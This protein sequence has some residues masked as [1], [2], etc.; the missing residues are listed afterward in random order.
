LSIDPSLEQARI[1]ELPAELMD[2]PPMYSLTLA[3]IR[4]KLES[5]HCGSGTLVKAGDRHFILTASHCIKPLFE[6]DQIGLPIRLGDRP[7]LIQKLPPIHVGIPACQDWGPDLAFIPLDPIDVANIHNS[8][9][10][11]FYNLDIHQEEMLSGQPK[12]DYHLWA[13]VGSPFDECDFSHPPRY[14]FMRNTFNVAIEKTITNHDFDYLEVRI[15]L[16]DYPST[17]LQGVSG[18]GLWHAEVERDKFTRA[19]RLLTAPRLEGVAFLRTVKQ[20]DGFPRIRFHG[21]RSIYQHGLSAIRSHF[22]R[23]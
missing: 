5:I 11:T 10:K 15:P 23:Q 18:G 17:Y 14:E 12:I 6:S 19:V 8:S 9:N 2:G 1:G 20:E 4:R 7:L 22:A 13:V 16:T 21:R 3:G